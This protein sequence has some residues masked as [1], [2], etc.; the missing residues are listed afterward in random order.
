MAS[1]ALLNACSSSEKAAS[2]NNVAGIYM[3]GLNLINPDYKV[4]HKNDS[5]TEV[6]FRLNSSDILY[7]KKKKRQYFQCKHFNQLPIK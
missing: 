1:V 2:N 6:H 7:T 4:F 3:P 5:V